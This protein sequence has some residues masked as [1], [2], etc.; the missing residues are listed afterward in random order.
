MIND[1]NI[2]FLS[3]LR[4]FAFKFLEYSSRMAGK[5]CAAS[6][7][8]NRFQHFDTRRM[9]L[10][11]RQLNADT[12]ESFLERACAYHFRSPRKLLVEHRQTNEIKT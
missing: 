6:Q 4:S 10:L 2:C 5:V 11:V 3:P 9:D 8:Y 7:N 12:T 1:D